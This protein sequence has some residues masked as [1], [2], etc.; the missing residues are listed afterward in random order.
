M[1]ARV[2]SFFAAQDLTEGNIPHNIIRFAVPLLIGNIAQQLYQMVDAIIVGQAVPGGLGAIGTTGPIINF[3]ILI[4]MA[5][6]TGSSVMVAQFFGARKMEALTKTI[7]NT[8][9]IVFFASILLM[10]IMIPASEPIL[11]WLNTPEEVLAMASDYLRITLIGILGIALYNIVS[12]I[13]RGLGDSFSPL[14]FLLLSTVLNIVL[15]ILFVWVWSWG[16][17][18]AAWATIIS[19]AISAILSIMRL[20][21]L[22]SIPKLTKHDLRLDKFLARELFRLGV[23][24]GI[25]QGIFSIAMLLVQNL[26]NLMGLTVIDANTAVIRIDAIAMMPNFTF[27]MA[28]M[29]FVGQ[30]IGANKMDRVKEGTKILLRM[31]VFVS[32]CTTLL[33]LVFGKQML[34]WF[35][36]NEDVIRIGY[37]MILI[38]SLGYIAVSISQVYGG[39]MRG[40]GDTLASMWIALLT[41][42]ILRTPLA[43]IFTYFTRSDEWPNG[44]PYWLQGSLL[45]AWIVGAIVNIIYFKSGKW[46]EKANIRREEKKRDIEESL[47]EIA[48]E[49]DEHKH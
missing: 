28:A 37:G 2:K 45:I 23:P 10:S 32:I 35:T 48:E 15:D 25:M 29:T 11:I 12:G 19:Q 24:A 4:Y 39:V 41:S 17:Q 13:L 31:S 14:L 26:I 34:S 42:I 27:G 36:T 1:L 43:Y 16:V 20:Y 8:L 38:L 18:G 33:M 21:R 5:I 44:S 46:R 6:A 40:A 9:L 49:I 22:D 3:M 30:N 7:G 47:A